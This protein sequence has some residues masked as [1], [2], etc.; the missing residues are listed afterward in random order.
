MF[1]FEEAEQVILVVGFQN[2]EPLVDQPA[3]TLGRALKDRGVIAVAGGVVVPG[4][5]YKRP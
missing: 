3:P 2:V 4:R 1:R 5:S